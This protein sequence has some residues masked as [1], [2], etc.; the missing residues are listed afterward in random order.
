MYMI[1]LAACEHSIVAASEDAQQCTNVT[2][3]MFALFSHAAF[4]F[5]LRSGVNSALW[6][7]VVETFCNSYIPVA[8]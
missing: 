7:I 2:H 4:T 8:V 6:N 1:H 5:C 3:Q